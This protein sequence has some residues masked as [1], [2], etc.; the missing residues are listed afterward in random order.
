MIDNIF[1][2]L[3]SFLINRQYFSIVSKAFGIVPFKTIFIIL[4]IRIIEV[5]MVICWWK[6]FTKAEEKGCKSLIPI[7][8]NVV[9]VQIVGLPIWIGLLIGVFPYIMVFVKNENILFLPVAI[10]G[11]LLNYNL[12]KAFRKDFKF[13]I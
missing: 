10:L 13:A 5:L 4:I 7:Y 11:Y 8:G 6:I 12:A 1:S 3:I 9:K 2:S